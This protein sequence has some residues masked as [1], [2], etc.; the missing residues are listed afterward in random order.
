MSLPNLLKHIG[1]LGGGR[2]ETTVG[3]GRGLRIRAPSALALSGRPSC[4]ASPCDPGG[5][6]LPCAGAFPEVDQSSWVG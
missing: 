1:R 6:A 5:G 3:R 4:D 2:G